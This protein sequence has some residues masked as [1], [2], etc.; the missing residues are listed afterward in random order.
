MGSEDL[1]RKGSVTLK[2]R[3]GRRLRDRCVCSWQSVESPISGAS[4]N[5]A[6]F[7]LKGCETMNIRLSA[8]RSLIPMV[9]MLMT[10]Q[11]AA[12]QQQSEPDKDLV[13]VLESV[14]GKWELVQYKEDGSVRRRSVKTIKGNSQ[15]VERYE[16]S[17]KKTGEDTSTFV[18]SKS[19]ATRV[20]TYHLPDGSTG[21]G[22]SYLYKVDADSLWEV[23]G[24]LERPEFDYPRFFDKPR[25]YEWKRLKNVK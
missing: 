21:K 1:L 12:A 22:H 17:G 4:V 19:G 18:L 8:S 9:F 23:W 25:M 15:V 2:C 6:G 10:F 24:L 20:M 7:C 5:S 14:Q 13:A 3:A 11:T 16:P